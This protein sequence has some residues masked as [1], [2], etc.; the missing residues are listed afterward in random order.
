MRKLTTAILVLSLVLGGVALAIA[1]DAPQA[2]QNVELSKFQKLTD[3]E[4]QEIRGTNMG[5][6]NMFGNTGITCP[7]STCVPNN[8]ILKDNSWGGPPSSR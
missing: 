3:K 6:G 2:S 1:A 8:C 7:Y 5:F 4:A